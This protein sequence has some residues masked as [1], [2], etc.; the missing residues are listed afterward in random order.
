MSAVHFR[1]AYKSKPFIMAAVKPFMW[2]MEKGISNDFINGTVNSI[3]KTINALFANVIWWD[4]N[5]FVP[6]FTVNARNTTMVVIKIPAIKDDILMIILLR[7][8]WKEFI[9]KRKKNQG[10]L[11]LL[12][13]VCW[14]KF[15][16]KDK[17]KRPKME[18]KTQ[19]IF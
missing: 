15:D 13:G 12:F 17:K 9:N 11:S 1:L 14:N 8:L 7:N 2:D 10:I 4:E 19:R 3:N 18:R 6:I 16:V 5:F